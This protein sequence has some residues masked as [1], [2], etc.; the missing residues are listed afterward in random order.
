MALLD[1]LVDLGPVKLVGILVAGILLVHIVP[2]F[3]DPYGLRK[4]PAPGLAAFTDFWLV[5][6]TRLGRRFQVLDEAHRKYGKYVRISPR[7]LSIADPDALQT[8]YGHGTGTMKPVFYDAFVG[9][10]NVRGLFNVR[11]RHEHTRKRKIVS[12]T[13]AQRNVLEFEPYIADVLKNFIKKWDHYTSQAKKNTADGWWKVDTLPWLNY[14]AFDIIGDL[15]FGSPFGMVEREA[16]LA[17]IE[18]LDGTV[19]H[20]PAVD[21]LNERGEYSNCLGVMQ[22]WLR[23]YIKYIDPWF[24]RGS[25][26]V[27]DLA[28]MARARVN[29]RLKT[30]AGDRKDLLARLQE[31]R[32]DNGNAMDIDELTAEA[33]TQLI[34]GSDTT[35]NSSCAIIF[36]LARNVEKQKKLQEELDKAFTVKSVDGV[37]EYE[38]AKVLPYLEACINEAL[39]MHSTSSM[40]LPRAMTECEFKGE[41]ISAGMECSVPAYTV[42]HLESIWGDPHTYRPERWLGEDAKQLDKSFIPFSVGPRSCVGRNLAFMELLKFMATLMYR[43]DFELADKNQTHLRTS[44]GFL[45]KPL[46]SHIKIRRREPKTIT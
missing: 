7:H 11:D 37:V 43:Y 8:V 24:A 21:I 6:Q 2:F 1:V 4:Y 29:E 44:E 46:E 19:I 42:H 10:K 20:V 31:A 3:L 14:L 17:A 25:K 39:R 34:A 28:G 22:P 16:D 26:A 45:R 18:Q 5:Y 40:G 27:K 9:L 36:Y 15:A 23:P 38:D 32:D 30:G 12:S 35:S 41:H 13:F 33:L